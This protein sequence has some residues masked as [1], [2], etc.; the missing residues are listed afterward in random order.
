MFRSGFVAL[1]GRPNVGKST[2]LNTLIGEK[3]A[4]ISEKPQTTRNQIRGILT[5]ADYQLVFLD[6]PGIHKPQ[7]K[8]GEKMVEIA[9]RTLQEVDLILFLADAVAGPGGGDEYVLEKL[10]NVKTPVILVIN[11]T[12]RS[13]RSRA[14]ELISHYSG[15]FAFQGAV[16]ISALEGTGTDELLQL[17]LTHLPE[18]P[19]YYPADMVTDQPERFIVAELIR[20]KL[21]QLTR[22]EVPHAIAVEIVSQRNRPGRELVDIE[23]NIYVERESQKG[24]VIGK[25]GML[26][27][28]A[29]RLARLDIEALLGVPVN[30][31]LWVKVKTDW[32]NK[33]GSWH[34]MGL[35]LE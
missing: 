7:H 33:T 21:L 19:L 34:S 4:I 2:L 15:L 20:E 29:G 35:E 6:T 32:R 22:D 8:L 12:D 11:K 10:K 13:G 16:A 18:G 14:L 1:T 3:M 26:L 25:G 30:L 5:T 9:L 24:I 28:E 31:K 23:A 17:M 27:K